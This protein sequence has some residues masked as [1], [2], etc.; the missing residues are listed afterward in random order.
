MRRGSTGGTGSNWAPSSLRL[1]SSILSPIDF[2]G[3]ALDT[4]LLSLVA[5]KLDCHETIEVKNRPVFDM[6]RIPRETED[7]GRDSGS[8]EVML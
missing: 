2:S 5:S 8:R 6:L 7:D 4:A 1:P 3:V